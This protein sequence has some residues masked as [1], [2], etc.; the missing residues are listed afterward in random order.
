MKKNKNLILGILFS[1][2][3]LFGC[4]SNKKKY[5]VDAQIEKT[6]AEIEMLNIENIDT[7]KTEPEIDYKKKFEGSYTI[8]V[9]G[10][11]SAQEVEVYALNENGGAIWLWVEN[12][13]KGGARIDDKKTGTWIATEN[14]ITI[15]ING[16]SGLISETYELKNNTLTNIQLPKRYL[17]KTE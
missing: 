10:V 17:K 16:N 15:N 2:T 14:G 3:L 9:K 7:L 12:D 13:G 5:D 11:S 1:L 6:E 8:E 4:D